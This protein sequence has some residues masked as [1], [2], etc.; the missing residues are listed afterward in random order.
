MISI[1]VPIYNVEKYLEKCIESILN[2]TY[3]DLEVI[4]VDDGSPDGSP[5]ICDRYAAQDSR[6]RVIHQINAGVSAARNAGLLAAKGTYIGFIDPDDFVASKMYE[7]MVSAIEES[8]S[9]LA[10]C[11]YEYYDEEY[12]V[13]EKRR[14]PVKPNE[15]I[16]RKE[17]MRRMSDM[18]P[19]VRHGVVNK[20][21]TKS[22]LKG[23]TFQEGLR[24]SEDVLF[25]TAYMERVKTA[26]FVHAPLYCNLVRQGSATH[27]G[28]NIQSL[29]DSFAAHEKMYRTIVDTYPDLKD[30]SLAFLLDVCLLKYNEAKGKLSSLNHESR[31]DAS[32]RMTDM[33]KFI[34]RMARQALFNREIFWKTRISYFFVK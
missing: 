13:D 22:A 14:Y 12:A 31:A 20:L 27:G 30:H 29:A 25:L 1:I 11:G 19:T 32:A 21:F 8:R 15:V 4:L 7:K 6:I 3:R 9:E 16:S 24:S 5:A 26:V 34:K 10:I 18:P 2:Q 23:L 33:R 17:L 28:L